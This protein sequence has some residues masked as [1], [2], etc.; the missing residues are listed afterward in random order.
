MRRVQRQS[1]LGLPKRLALT[2]ARV[3]RLKRIKRLRKESRLPAGGVV[4]TQMRI[5]AIAPVCKWA[6]VLLRF[7]PR[8]LCL[9]HMTKDVW[10]SLTGP[11]ALVSIT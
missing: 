2:K 7:C 4:V 1:F 10:N 6:G 3:S 11:G 9:L 8:P 5:N